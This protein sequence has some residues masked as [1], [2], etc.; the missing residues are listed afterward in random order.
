M[1]S[2]GTTC[3]W[4]QSLQVNSFVLSNLLP[5]FSTA[6]FRSF[7]NTSVSGTE[8]HGAQFNGSCFGHAGT[9]EVILSV[10]LVK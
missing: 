8:R 9:E 6:A 10:N 3:S 2:E 4:F 1:A 7:W 5:W